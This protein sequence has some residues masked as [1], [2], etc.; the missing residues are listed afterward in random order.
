MTKLGVITDGIS[1]EFEQALTVMNEFGLTQAELQYLWDVEVGDLSDAQMD[2]V[3][4][5]VAA[6]G[7]EVSCVSRHIFGG[8]ALGELSTE[9]PAYREHLAALHRCI[10]MAQA[11]DCPLARIMSFK[12]EMIL[13]G[14][15][16]AEQWNV[17]Q[18]AWAR[19]REL[20]GGA[21]Q[22]AEDRAITLVMETGNNA[23]TNSAFLARRMVDEV[24]SARL[25]V[26]W[27]PANALYSTEAPY[28]DGYEAL[29]GGCLGHIHLKDVVVEIA[30][31]TIA[32]RQLGTGQMAPYLEDM[33][34]ALKADGYA[35]SISLESVYRP[36]G[37]SFEDGFRASVG[38]LK[39]LFS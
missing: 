1:R 32:C 21:A 17:A 25:K 38:A 9:A 7:V 36:L 11:L 28:P 2:R 31:A 34:T 4:R 27:D 13:F 10:D 15:F 8:L 14:S 23:I 20:I 19:A 18:G 39:A 33:A 26:M 37:G 16:G 30:K 35:G 24:G 29:R 22:I 3:Q 5:L 6:H 12:K